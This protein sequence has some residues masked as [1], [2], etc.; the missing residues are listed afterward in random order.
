MYVVNWHPEMIM[1][2]I[3]LVLVVTNINSSTFL[4]VNVQFD[5]KIP[6]DGVSEL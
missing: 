6:R 4:F 2:D 5:I 1:S 3:G